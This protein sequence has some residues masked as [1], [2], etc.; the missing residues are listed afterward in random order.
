ME[1]M[2]CLKRRLSDLVFATMLED[3]EQGSRDGPGR[4]PSNDSDSSVTGSQLT[5]GSSDKPL[6]GPVISQR[7][8][9]LVR[10]SGHREEP[11]G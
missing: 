8:A 1:A 2:R 6:P 10:A 4:E 9:P 7:R 11:C 5:T 3:L